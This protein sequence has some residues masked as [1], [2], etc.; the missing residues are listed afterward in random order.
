MRVSVV[1]S[2]DSGFRHNPFIKAVSYGIALI[3]VLQQH[4]LCLSK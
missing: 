3:S 4:M 1:E 2:V